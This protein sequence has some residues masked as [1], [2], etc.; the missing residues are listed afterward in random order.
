M[1]EIEGRLVGDTP[2]D[3]KPVDD[4]ISVD[5]GENGQQ[6]TAVIPDWDVKMPGG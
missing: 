1:R 6:P 5:N 2:V 3:Q 4:L